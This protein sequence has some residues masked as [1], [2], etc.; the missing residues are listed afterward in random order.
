MLIL[1]GQCLQQVGDLVMVYMA[2][3]RKKIQL[4]IEKRDERLDYALLR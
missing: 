2:A 3:V 1:V 4:T